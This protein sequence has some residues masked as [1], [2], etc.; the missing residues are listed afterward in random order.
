M[1]KRVLVAF[2]FDHTLIDGNSDMYI[3]RLLPDGGQLPSSIKKLYSASGW[4]DY[5][6]EVFRYLHSNQVTKERLLA[7]VTEIPMVE[8]MHELLEYLAASK[9]TAVKADLNF[10]GP[11]AESSVA[12][13]INRESRAKVAD[14]AVYAEQQQNSVTKV[15]GT[16]PIAEVDGSSA[17]GHHHS[18]GNNLS[19]SA[20]QFDAIIVSDANSVSTCQICLYCQVSVLL[21]TLGVWKLS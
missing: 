1:V 21:V 4:I 20:V 3:L 15:V 8:G 2:D 7:C 5:Q 11:V 12:A 17:E 9:T 13:S 18:A 16:V 14:N 10:V 6:Q 19:D